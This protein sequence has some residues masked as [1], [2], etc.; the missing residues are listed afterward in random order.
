[1]SWQPAFNFEARAE[2]LANIER[3]GERIAAYVEEFCRERFESGATEFRMSELTEHVRSRS[4][5]APD[6]AGRILRDLRTRKVLDYE[7]VRRSES[8]YRLTAV[9]RES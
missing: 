5:I 1:M 3:V 6:S 4:L 7:V 8:L 2:Q 9:N